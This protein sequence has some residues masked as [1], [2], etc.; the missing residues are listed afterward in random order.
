MKIEYQIP[1]IEISMCPSSVVICSLS[2][3]ACYP[4]ELNGLLKTEDGDLQPGNK[5]RLCQKRSS[6]DAGANKTGA[7]NLFSGS[8][9][10]IFIEHCIGLLPRFNLLYSITPNPI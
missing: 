6:I 9:E 10:E 2:T 5:L 4:A 1:R 8:P 3:H 7:D